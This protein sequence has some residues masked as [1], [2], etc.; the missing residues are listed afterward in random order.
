MLINTLVNA[1]VGTQS[2][3]A[4]IPTRES[5]T[6]ASMPDDYLSAKENRLAQGLEQTAIFEQPPRVLS[7]WDVRL[8][9]Q[10]CVIR[11]NTN[12]RIE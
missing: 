3:G 12:E 11:V 5:F 1:A 8:S 9:V 10:R 2:F 4:L 6:S 7:R